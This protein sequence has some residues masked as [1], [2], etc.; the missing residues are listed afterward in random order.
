[1][2]NTGTAD[3]TIDNIFINGKPY[4]SYTNVSI[5]PDVSTPYTLA[6]GKSADF[7][8]TIPDGAGFTSGQSIEVKIHTASGQEY[9]KLTNLP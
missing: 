5:T 1:M 4:S 9:P 6:A 2:T 8:I 7:E 3:A